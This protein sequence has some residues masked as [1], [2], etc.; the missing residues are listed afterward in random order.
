MRSRC[1]LPYK[2][3]ISLIVA[4]VQRK[5]ALYG[6][7]GQHHTWFL[8][9]PSQFRRGGMC[10]LTTAAGCIE[11]RVIW[12]RKSR[13]RPGC[14]GFMHGHVLENALKMCMLG[15]RQQ[16]ER[17]EKKHGYKYRIPTMKQES[18]RPTSTSTSMKATRGMS[19]ERVRENRETEIRETRVFLVRACQMTRRRTTM[20]SQSRATA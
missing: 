11:C 13:W 15:D 4:T 3:R 6:A 10:T 17:G 5:P 19:I 7:A 2:C 18:N 9:G 16:Q 20:P 12:K 1:R 8:V 14:I